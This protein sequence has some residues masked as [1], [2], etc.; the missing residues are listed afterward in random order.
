MYGAI[1]DDE[2]RSAAGESAGFM[3]KRNSDRALAELPVLV[4]SA[5]LSEPIETP[6]FRAKRK[7]GSG[8]GHRDTGVTR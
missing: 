7:P 1:I 2:R 3:G 6:P 4:L 8:P 5:R